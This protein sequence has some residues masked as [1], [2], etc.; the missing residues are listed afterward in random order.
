[1]TIAWTTSRIL[2]ACAPGDGL[3]MG[4]G[5][6]VANFCKVENYLAM[7]EETH[8]GNEEHS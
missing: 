7:L 2:E 1:L 3:I 5:N 4:S 8:R 6:S